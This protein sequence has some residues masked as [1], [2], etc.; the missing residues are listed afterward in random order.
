MTSIKDIILNS[1]DLKFQDAYIEEW[2]VTVRVYGFTDEQVGA[3]RAKSQALRMKQRRGDGD[4][5]MEVEMKHRRAEL[6]VKCL[7]DPETD[8]RIFTDSDAPRLAQKHAGVLEG[9]DSL[10]TDLSGLNK[11]YA[12][13]VKDAEAD[14]S[15][16]QS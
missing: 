9:L 12:E 7:R 10:A 5:D 15:S 2:G 11:S 6:L 13:Q 8:K 14:F 3:W 4:V 1:S 16:D